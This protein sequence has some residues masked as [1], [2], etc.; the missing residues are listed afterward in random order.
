MVERLRIVFRIFR[1]SR[2][3]RPL[4]RP[5]YGSLSADPFGFQRREEAFHGGVVPYVSGTAHR[6][7]DAIVGDQPLELLT[8]I[9][10]AAVRVMQRRIREHARAPAKIAINNASVTSCALISAFI[11]QPTTRRENRSITATT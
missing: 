7:V 10:A 1:C 4:R 6:K 2:T 3:R 5:A 9:L 11:D 8:R